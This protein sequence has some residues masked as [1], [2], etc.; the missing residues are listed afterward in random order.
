MHFCFSAFKKTLHLKTLHLKTF[1]L[2]KTPHLYDKKLTLLVAISITIS[3]I[4]CATA[5]RFRKTANLP[6]LL[7]ESSGLMTLNGG[8]T[9]WTHNDSGGEPTI[10]EIE[11]KNGEVLRQITLTNAKNIDWEDLT[12]DEDGNIYIGDFGNN[13]MKRKNLCIY[14]FNINKALYSQMISSVAVEKI[15]FAYPDQTAFPPKKDNRNFDCESIVHYKKRLYLFSKNHSTPYNGYTKLYALPDRPNTVP[16]PY[17][18]ARQPYTASLIDSVKT[19][20]NKYDSWI[21]S[22]ALSPDA[23]ELVLLSS[24]RLFVFSDWTGDNFFSGKRK[25]VLLPSFSQKEGVCFMDKNTLLISD[26]RTRK[27][28]G[29]HLY[30]FRLH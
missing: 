2:K 12:H 23:Q 21:T 19:G 30:R 4:S 18:A 3:I 8:A 9:V 11:P 5:H 6:A 25:I 10:Y 15:E 20:N 13:K 29:G 14:K 16:Q 26:E 27:L 24:D 22:A 7:H 17:T 1:T 28:L